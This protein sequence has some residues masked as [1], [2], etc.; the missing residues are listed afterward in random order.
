MK[1]LF[2]QSRALLFVVTRTRIVHGVVKPDGKFHAWR[3]CQEPSRIGIVKF[4]QAFRDVTLVVVMP[5]RFGVG[6]RQSL[7]PSTGVPSAEGVRQQAQI[8]KIV[9]WPLVAVQACLFQARHET[10]S[11]SRAVRSL[12]EDR[13]PA[14]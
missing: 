13:R 11:R 7:V 2:S 6:G 14:L 4:A 9:I 1:K 8:T 5:L 12:F 3:V 10:D